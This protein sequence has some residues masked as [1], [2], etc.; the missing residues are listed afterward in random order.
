M[1]TQEALERA[2][3]DLGKAIAAELAASLA[4]TL[5]SPTR[6]L[7]LE[8]VGEALGLSR[9]SVQ[10]LVTK[11]LLE[12]VKVGPGEQAIRVE[13]GELERYLQTRRVA[14]RSVT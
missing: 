1:S 3:V 10:D 14:S 11:G 8:Q 4:D 6:L 5:P 12:A 13:Q 9:R 7:T 2:V